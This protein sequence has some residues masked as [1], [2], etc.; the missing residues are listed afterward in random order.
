VTALH[1]VQSVRYGLICYSE[2]D[3]MIAS[4]LASKRTDR[5]DD[6]TTG[7]VRTDYDDDNDWR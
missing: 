5:S 7:T 4:S 6:E 1:P 2:S 3:V